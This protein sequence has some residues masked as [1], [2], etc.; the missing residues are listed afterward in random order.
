MVVIR[1]A[2][3]GSKKSPFYHIVATDQRNAR[4]GRYIERLGFYNPMARGNAAVIELQHDRVQYWIGQGAQTTD[5][6]STLLKRVKKGDVKAMPSRMEEKKLQVEKTA[7]AAK[8]KLAA[9][10]KA[11]EEAAKA[12]A[13]QASADEA[14]AA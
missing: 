10:I 12:E 5:R 6:M 2:R 9:S 4:D 14:P 13:A 8:K 1:L 11:A 3:G 7:E